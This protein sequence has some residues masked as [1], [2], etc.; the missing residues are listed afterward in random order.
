MRNW[1]EILSL[2][3]AYETRFAVLH[4]LGGFGQGCLGCMAWLV[5][6]SPSALELLLPSDRE[7]VGE[8]IL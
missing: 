2:G 6:G 1:V 5:R 3:K 8:A 7:N 4:C